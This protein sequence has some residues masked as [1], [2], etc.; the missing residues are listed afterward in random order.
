MY[1]NHWTQV[2]PYHDVV[3]SY[4]FIS[5]RSVRR[6]LVLTDMEV[7]LVEPG[8]HRLGCGVVHF[9]GFLQVHVCLLTLLL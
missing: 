8:K 2:K 7:L 4:D 6:F 3:M 5:C 1:G 9:I